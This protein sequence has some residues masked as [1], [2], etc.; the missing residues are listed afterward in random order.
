[1]KII[2]LL[3]FAT[4]VTVTASGQV[5]FGVKA[6]I[7]ITTL[8]LSTV[9]SGFSLGTKTD[10]N[11]GAF[12]LVPIATSC[13]LQT[14]LMYSGQGA[15]TS[16]L[17]SSGKLDYNYLNVPILFKYQHEMGLFAE[18]GPQI[19]FLLSANEKANG[20]TLN[21]KDATQS[22]DFSWAFGIGYKF[23]EIGLGIDARYNLG[24]TNV[25]KN[26][27]NSNGTEKNSVFQLGLF[28]IFGN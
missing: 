5:Q 10:F 2:L 9:P 4:V 24:L 19:G 6:G 12:A 14:E 22:V 1:M 27:S 25:S 3:L 23:S 20:Q 16:V 18:S 21:A 17:G 15:S 11:A 28:Y 13:F 26:N 7:N 8:T